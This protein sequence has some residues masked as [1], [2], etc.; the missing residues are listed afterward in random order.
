MQ[1]DS[2]LGAD[3]AKIAAGSYHIKGAHVNDYEHF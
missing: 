1:L 3:L 2:I